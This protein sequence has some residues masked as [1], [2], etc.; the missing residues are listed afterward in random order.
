MHILNFDSYVHPHAGVVSPHTAATVP[1]TTRFHLAPPS[2]SS[3]RRAWPGSLPPVAVPPAVAAWQPAAV[4]THTRPLRISYV[5]TSS[6]FSDV[7]KPLWM[8]KER[9]CSLLYFLASSLLPVCFA[10]RLPVCFASRLPVCEGSR[11]NNQSAA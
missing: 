1:W 3:E 4:A 10:S 11:M 6:R 2:A 5:S 7:Q 8:I 9:V